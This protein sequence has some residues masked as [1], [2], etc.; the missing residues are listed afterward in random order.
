MITLLDRSDL[1]LT[2]PENREDIKMT[3]SRSF[4]IFQAPQYGSKSANENKEK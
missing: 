4:I 1:M 2:L 3:I